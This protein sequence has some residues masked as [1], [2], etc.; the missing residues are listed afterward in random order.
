MRGAD[1]A[2]VAAQAAT[3]PEDL[4]AAL[5]CVGFLRFR[6]GEYPAGARLGRGS[7]GHA[8]PISAA[9]ADALLLL[10]MCATETYDLIGG[11]DCYLARHRAEPP[12]RLRPCA[13]PGIAQPVRRCLRA[14]WPVRTGPGRRR[15]G[16]APGSRTWDARTRLVADLDDGLGLLADRPA[17][18][19]PRQAGR[20]WPRSPGPAHWVKATCISSPVTWRWSKAKPKTRPPAYARTRAIADDIGSQELGVLVRL[21]FSRLNRTMANAPA[22]LSWTAD[23]LTIIE[24]MGYRHLQ[25]ITLIERG[26]AAWALEDMMLAEADF[27]AAQAVLEPLHASFDLAA[28]RCCLRVCCTLVTRPTLAAPGSKPRPG[29]VRAGMRSC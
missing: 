11:E 7:L 8:L 13:A 10:G 21:G 1:T 26:R 29:L 18:A 3:S 2:L 24:R 17:R 20:A 6:S 5:V 12:A 25:G 15:G 22:A 19:C 14:A 27:R 9:A 16:A 23:A 28:P 4:A